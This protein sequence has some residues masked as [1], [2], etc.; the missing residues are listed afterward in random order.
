MKE[1]SDYFC[2]L[3]LSG[4]EGLDGFIRSKAEFSRALKRSPGN[5]SI[6]LQ[7]AGTLNFSFEILARH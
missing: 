4:Q 1:R 6:A 2:E 5:E 7:R 3:I